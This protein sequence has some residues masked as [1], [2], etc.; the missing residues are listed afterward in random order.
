MVRSG[1]LGMLT[2]ACERGLWSSPYEGC[3]C[4]W[5]AWEDV[6]IEETL[7]TTIWLYTKVLL[8][9]PDHILHDRAV[10]ELCFTIP[11]MTVF[12]EVRYQRGIKLRVL[13]WL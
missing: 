1:K 6:S 2:G 10:S 4:L 12:L 9:I 7:T 13:P 3:Y 5:I 8:M 11:Q